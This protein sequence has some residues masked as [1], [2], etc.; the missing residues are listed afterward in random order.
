MSDFP[1]A[2][3]RAPGLQDI[4][5]HKLDYRVVAD[6]AEQSDAQADGW[7]LTSAEAVKSHEASRSVETSGESAKATVAHDAENGA[8]STALPPSG[9]EAADSAPVSDD[10]GA[11]ADPRAE[12]EA[13]AVAL[14]IKFD[15][16]TSDKKLAE[17][18]A[19]KG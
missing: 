1:K 18:I 5:G 15:G 7:F 9:P 6:E 12:L 2:M 4:H 19:K 16:R 8:S 14:G 10:A 17:A 11:A 3:Y 13:K